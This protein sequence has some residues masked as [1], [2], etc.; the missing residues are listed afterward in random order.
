MAIARVR[1]A[2]GL[3]VLSAGLAAC[4]QGADAQAGGESGSL[5]A[6]HLRSQRSGLCRPWCLNDTARR[7][8]SRPQTTA[9]E[10]GNASAAKIA[11][12]ADMTALIT[13]YDAELKPRLAAIASTVAAMSTPPAYAYAVD[14]LK[15]L[16][17]PSHADPERRRQLHRAHRG[18]AAQQQRASARQPLRRHRPSRRLASGSARTATNGR[19]RISSRSRQ[20]SSPGATDPIVMPRGRTN[21]D[22]ECEFDV[23]IGKKA[24][25]VPVA[26]AADYI[27]GYTIQI[28][29]SDRGGRGDR[30]WAA[31]TG[32]SARITTPFG[33]LGPFIVPKEFHRDP[34]NTRHVF[35]LSGTVMQDSNTNRMDHNIFELLSL[36]SNILTLNPGDVI[37]GGS[38]GHE[39]RAG[40]ATMDEGRRHGGLRNRRHRQ[41]DAPGRRRGAADK[42]VMRT[43]VAIA[44]LILGATIAAGGQTVDQRLTGQLKRLF[45]D[46]SAFSP[47]EGSPPHFKAF[48]SD[49]Q[50]GAR[51][52]VG[53]AFWTTELE[54]LE[55]GYDGPIKILVGVNPKGTLAGVVVVDHH[56]PYGCFLGRR[57]RSS[58]RSSREGHP[59]RVQGWRRCGCRVAG[60]DDGDERGAG[61]QKWRQETGERSS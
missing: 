21:I 29:V 14:T 19:T 50:T 15:P 5:Q 3:A 55:R 54:P 7:G 37:S 34:M 40:G 35:T 13:R 22:Y 46:A 44:T 25:Y 48:V 16:P 28:D 49:P 17:G 23:V 47:K 57:C 1:R 59:R 56:E 51:T 8:P 31:R 39:H 61:D 38:G 53:Y 30:K 6:G 11:M 4:N 45:P 2:L 36:A 33:P 58:P 12:P 10:G 43:P 60:D 20:P 52:V 9:W 41:A 18:I 24:S 32:S 26:N 42:L 27:F